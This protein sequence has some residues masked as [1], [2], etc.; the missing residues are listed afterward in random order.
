MFK[1]IIN[2]CLGRLGNRV[3]NYKVLFGHHCAEH[4]EHGTLVGTWLKEG[5]KTEITI[6][7]FF[8]GM[9]LPPRISM[10]VVEE[11]FYHARRAGIV[12]TH[13]YSYANM[14]ACRPVAT[15]KRVVAPVKH[16]PIVEKPR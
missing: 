11:L 6:P 2:A 15:H 14:A 7:F 8:D 10:E 9:M 3:Q 4:G 13:I 12:P 16:Q 5:N 1:K